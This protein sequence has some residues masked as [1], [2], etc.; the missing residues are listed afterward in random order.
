MEPTRR[1]VIPYSKMLMESMFAQVA[2]I[3]LEHGM[4][5]SREDE[6]A[7]ADNVLHLLRA[8]G[9]LKDNDEIL[10]GRFVLLPSQLPEVSLLPA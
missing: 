5:E 9:H 10:L 3:L 1:N 2:A 8:H 7:F 4:L 6:E